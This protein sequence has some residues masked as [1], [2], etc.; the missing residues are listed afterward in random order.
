VVE[1]DLVLQKLYHLPTTSAD[2]FSGFILKT[3][4]KMTREIL[5]PQLS[6][7]SRA[8]RVS[9][10]SVTL[11]NLISVS[12][13]KCYNCIGTEAD[14]SKD[15]LKK[16]S[17]KETTCSLG[18][19]RCMRL[20]NKDGDAKAVINSCSNELLCK[21]A[22]DAKCDKDDCA[23]GCCDTDLCNAGSPVSFSVFLMTVCTALG[24]ALLK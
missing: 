16:D 14:C 10:K 7:L 15:E 3:T 2:I 23:A 12:A 11:S 13:L 24:L 6:S 1:G 18:L 4:T 22:K 9:Y 8:R 17:S 19:D 21:I 20:W 5:L